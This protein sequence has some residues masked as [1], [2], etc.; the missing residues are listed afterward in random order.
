MTAKGRLVIQFANKTGDVSNAEQIVDWLL[1]EVPSY[2]V[3]RALADHNPD[4]VQVMK[5]IAHSTDRLMNR[6]DL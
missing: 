1:S 4:T 5:G 2:D 3:L 6:V